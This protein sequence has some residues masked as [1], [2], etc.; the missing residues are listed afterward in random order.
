MLPP[1]LKAGAVLN[2]ALWSLGT[3]GNHAVPARGAKKRPHC[4]GP[5]GSPPEASRATPGPPEHR[6][7]T[8][9]ANGH[10]P[11]PT[12]LPPLAQKL[13]K[14]FPMRG[15]RGPQ[16][17]GRR[18]HSSPPSSSSPNYMP[19]SSSITS[20][21]GGG[22]YSAKPRCSRSLP[23]IWSRISVCSWRKARTLSRPWP[24]RSEP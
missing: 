10:G 6:R 4:R 1:A 8:S 2:S 3:Y 19:S 5:G 12:G 15:V 11:Q 9:S 7:I 14:T 21:V 16:A 24:R 17:P 23:S 22:T 20:G 13:F 18:R